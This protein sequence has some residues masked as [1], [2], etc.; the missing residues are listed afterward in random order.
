MPSTTMPSGF[1]L[2]Y[3]IRFAPRRPESS[4][5]ADARRATASPAAI[6]AVTVSVAGTLRVPSVELLPA[7]RQAPE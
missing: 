7:V 2:K 6:W 4:L 1:Y 3:R 5:L